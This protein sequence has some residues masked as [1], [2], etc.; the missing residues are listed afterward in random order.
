MRLTLPHR[1]PSVQTEDNVTFLLQQNIPKNA[2]VLGVSLGGLVAARLQ[3][4]GGVLPSR[5]GAPV[6]LRAHGM[7]PDD[8]DFIARPPLD[9]Q[10]PYLRTARTPREMLRRNVVFEA[11]SLTVL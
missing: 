9:D 2:I 3:E 11:R 1:D 6:L 7:E 8:P 10:A 5:I 4:V